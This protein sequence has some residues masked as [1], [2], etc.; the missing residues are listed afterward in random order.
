MAGL[1]RS[2]STLLSSIL[3]QNPRIYSGPSSP[4][5]PMMMSLESSLNNEELFLAYPKPAQGKQ[6]IAQIIQQWYNNIDRPVIIDKNRS[7]TDRLHYISGYL[8]LRPRVLFPVRDVSEILAS[9]IAL[10]RRNPMVSATGR[11]NFIDDMLIKRN[12]PLDDHHRCEV[13]AG[14]EGILGQSLNSLRSVLEQGL[15]NFIHIIEYRDLVSRPQETLRGIY[16]FLGE[17][18]YQHDFNNVININRERDAEVYGFADMHQVNPRVAPSAIDPV[19]YLSPI[20]LEQCRGQEFWR[21]LSRRAPAAVEQ[22]PTQESVV[23]KPEYY[24]EDPGEDLT[25][26]IIG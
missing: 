8:D 4:V 15:D 16:D 13:L 20:I 21:N 19:Q 6:I 11:I 3:N 5:V 9:F 17:T 10:H 14:P 22:D 26:A 23:E 1:P 2:G 12:R 18:Y 24:D 25:G 7:W